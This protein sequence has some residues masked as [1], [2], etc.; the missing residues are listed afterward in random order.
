MKMKITRLIEAPNVPLALDGKVMV[1]SEEIEIIHLRLMTG[2]KLDKHQNPFDTVF[3]IL[4]G[5]AIIKTDEA[6][7][8]AEPD[9]VIELCRTVERSVENTGLTDFR[10]L[11]IKKLLTS[12]K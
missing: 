1:K 11:V 7:V 4:E 6:N 9:M 8:I 3:Y 5:Q 2:E 12:Q 10:M